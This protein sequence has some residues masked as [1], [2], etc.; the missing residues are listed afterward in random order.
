MSPQAIVQ[1]ARERSI[2]ILGIC[3]HNSAENV[4]A[5][6]DAGQKVQVW[7]LPGIEVTSQEE[8]HILALFDRIENALKLQELIYSH[9]PGKNDE[10][11]FGMQVVVNQDGEVLRFNE[12]LLIGASV[13]SI[14]DVVNEIHSLKGLAI[15]SHIDRESFSLIGQL[16]FIPPELDLDAAEISPQISIDEAVDK[17]HPQL[18]LICSSD[19]HF[20]KDIGKA[21][22]LFYIEEGTIGEIKKALMKEAGRKVIH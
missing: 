3:D 14:S 8:I 13:L 11:A 18:P 20:L 16:G 5:L 2:D 4:P 1:T 22:T 10:E 9:L 21:S 7:I 12:K 6:I 19:A 15:A 17:F